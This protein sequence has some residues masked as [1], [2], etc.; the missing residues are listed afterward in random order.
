MI[1]EQI[2]YYIENLGHPNLPTFLRRM[3]D[4]GKDR[5]ELVQYIE[6]SNTFIYIFKRNKII[7]EA[8][9]N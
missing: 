8:V 4:L 7:D 2:E 6:T 5:W 1:T 9:S 3:N